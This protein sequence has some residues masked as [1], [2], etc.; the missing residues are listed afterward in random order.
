MKAAA[1]QN[2]T[3]FAPSLLRRALATVKSFTIDNRKNTVVTFNLPDELEYESIQLTKLNEDTAKYDDITS[4]T[5]VKVKGKKVTVT[6]HYKNSY[7]LSVNGKKASASEYKAAIDASQKSLSKQKNGRVDAGDYIQ[8]KGEG[9]N[10]AGVPE[11]DKKGNPTGTY[12]R[13]SEV[14]WVVMQI[15]QPKNKPQIA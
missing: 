14:D 5:N 13:T 15:A 6:T 11:Y 7:T 12:L 2:A 3:R 4:T 10:P 8:G 1:H 9:P